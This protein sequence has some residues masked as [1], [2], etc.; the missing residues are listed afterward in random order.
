MEPINEPPPT[1]IPPPRRKKKKEY[2]SID[3]KIKDTCLRII[4]IIRSPDSHRNPRRY[5]EVKKEFVDCC[6]PKLTELGDKESLTADEKKLLHTLKSVYNILFPPKLD[7]IER[8]PK[9]P[10]KNPSNVNSKEGIR[11]VIPPGR[12]APIAPTLISEQELRF[13]K[14]RSEVNISNAVLLTRPHK[15]LLE[16]ID[17][18]IILKEHFKK[19]PAKL[20]TLESLAIKYATALANLGHSI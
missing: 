18:I 2:N 7:G 5:T 6:L 15:Q 1:N 11:K 14:L 13:N 17:E 4:R 12:L 16:S 3:A 19:D 8:P 20:A 9:A 10:P